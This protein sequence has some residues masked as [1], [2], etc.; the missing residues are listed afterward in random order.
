MIALI[1]WC[2][3]LTTP[4]WAVQEATT[5][6]RNAIRARYV[7]LPYIYTLFRHA[8]TTGLPVMRP[9]W[10]EFPEFPA[11][12]AVE[13]E[14]LLGPGLLVSPMLQARETPYPSAWCLIRLLALCR[15]PRCWSREQAHAR[16]TSRAQGPGTTP[17]LA[18]CHRQTR[19][20]PSR[21]RSTW[22][23]S[24]HSYEEGTSRPLG[25]A[26]DESVWNAFL[27]TPR[28]GPP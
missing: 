13:D 15:L 18:L 24:H 11:T 23:A 26:L 12:Y 17:G 9:L 20:A 25:C 7:L 2:S 1:T 19:L 4:T 27:T 28:Y 6:I 21:C 8:N 14:F 22:T 16:S 5:R 3:H 10:F